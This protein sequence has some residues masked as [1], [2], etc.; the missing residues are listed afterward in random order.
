[1]AMPSS[2]PTRVVRLR[3]WLQTTAVE[4]CFPTPQKGALILKDQ[5]RTLLDETLTL[6]RLQ[7]RPEDGSF[8]ATHAQRLPDG[9]YV[10]AHARAKRGEHNL[11]R[12]DP[13]GRFLGS[14]AIGDGVAH[15]A[16]DRRGQIWVGYFDEGIFG[17]DP[18]SAYGLSRFDLNGHLDFQ[19]DGASHGHI[20]DCD[21]L[22]LDDEDVAWICA[23]SDY[24]V[25]TI[26]ETGTRTV[27]SKAPVSIISGLLA[28]R[29][30]LGFLGGVDFHGVS[31]KGGFVIHTSPEGS[32]I[33]ELPKVGPDLTP[34]DSIVTVIAQATG[35]RTQVQLLDENAGPISFR[36]NVSCR[37][38]TA[39]C[40]NDTH[41]YRFDLADLVAA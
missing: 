39:L 23:Y 5:G 19:W 2:I 37:A 25:A 20:D 11:E 13:S 7:G 9:G 31:D 3:P 40:W 21:A 18:L 29:D 22:T 10:L 16:A 27:L 4:A 28:G 12:F 15:L 33:E 6:I 35:R 1:M 26:T 30:H 41:I 36:G 17:G 38:G 8:R 24:F 34:K 32:R 14:F